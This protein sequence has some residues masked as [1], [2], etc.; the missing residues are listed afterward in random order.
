MR[1]QWMIMFLGRCLLDRG[2]YCQNKK[3]ARC[4]VFPSPW[5]LPNRRESCRKEGCTWGK[6]LS[7][8]KSSHWLAEGLHDINDIDVPLD[9]QSDVLLIW[10]G[11]SNG[12][13]YRCDQWSCYDLLLMT[14]SLAEAKQNELSPRAWCLAKE[15]RARWYV[16]ENSE[17][18]EEVSRRSHQLS[19]I[20]PKKNLSSPRGWRL[21]YEVLLTRHG[22][23]EVN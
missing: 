4:S 11:L 6:E 21:C 5:S 7:F 18:E 9:C 15:W 19:K 16:E 23:A 20:Y 8:A 17:N 12:N 3:G 22:L 2:W 14:F 10:C 1:A 13:R